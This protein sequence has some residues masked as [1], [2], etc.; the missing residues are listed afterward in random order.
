MNFRVAKEQVPLLTLI[1]LAIAWS[2][3][4]W[5]DL[6]INDY[7]ASR[8]D[9]LLLLD[10]AL[11]IPTVCFYCIKDKQQALLK[12]VVYASILILV[13][14]WVI[15]EANKSIWQWV[16]SLR[17]LLLLGLVAFELLTLY[18]V[19]FAIKVALNL[20]RDPDQ[21]IASAVQSRFG[22]S[23]IA[24]V[25]SFEAR[26]WTF[27]LFA[28]RCAKSQFIGEH[29]FLGYQKD[30]AQ[31]NAFAFILLLLIELPIVHLL[32]HFIASP[33]AANIVSGLTLFGLIYFIAEYRAL[34]IRPTS[35]T[36]SRLI[37]RYGVWQP[38]E[39]ELSCIASVA[40]HSEYVKRGA[41]IKRFN[42]SGNPNIHLTLTNGQHIYLGLDKP[43]LFITSLTQ[44]MQRKFN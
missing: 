27:C 29:H 21:T 42:L 35:I 11:I 10:I 3:F 7:G 2:C 30:G 5:F 36:E 26:V 22:Q 33:V 18:T 13:G 16:E 20:R 25:L 32:L 39:I 6:W 24:T 14:S 34:A 44:A 4:Y 37:I 15:P 8:Y 31:S 19:F 38:M 1:V 12:S 28:H 9:W 23:W 41:N 40:S 17:Y 43:K